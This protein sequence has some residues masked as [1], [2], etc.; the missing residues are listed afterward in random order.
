L[1]GQPLL[2]S[3]WWI[4]DYSL[5]ATPIARNPMRLCASKVVVAGW[6]DEQAAK[7]GSNFSVSPLW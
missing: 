1:E 2:S 3:F 7:S 5:S 6:L 4:V